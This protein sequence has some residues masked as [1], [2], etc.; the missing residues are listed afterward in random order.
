MLNTIRTTLGFFVAVIEKY[1]PLNFRGD[2]LEHTYNFLKIS[3]DLAT[4]GQPTEQQIRLMKEAGYQVVINLA[5]KSVLENSLQTERS[6]VEALGIEYIHIPVDFSNPTQGNFEQFVSSMQAH[7]GQ[8]VWVH[9]AANARVS[10]FVYKYRCVVL[11]DNKH[12]A[13]EDLKKI[14]QPWGVWKAFIA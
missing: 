4:S 11:G 9:C 6:L 13:E 3:D 8:K 5:P 7:T 14:W 12:E 1:T 10:A 2:T